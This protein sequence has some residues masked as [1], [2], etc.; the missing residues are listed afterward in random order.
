M[1][2]Y[3]DDDAELEN[4]ELWLENQRYDFLMNQIDFLYETVMCEFLLGKMSI[5]HPHIFS[6]MLKSDF[7]NWILYNNYN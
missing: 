5:S 4:E 3:L 1:D 7:V 2:D 6:F